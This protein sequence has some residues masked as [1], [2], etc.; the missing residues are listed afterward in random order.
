MN[1]RDEDI[2]STAQ[3]IEVEADRLAAIEHEKQ[4]LDATDPRLLD[5]SEE[6]EEISKRLVPM[7][8]AEHSLVSESQA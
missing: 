2:R 6:A 1:E 8:T 3:S 4:S 7:T 5:L